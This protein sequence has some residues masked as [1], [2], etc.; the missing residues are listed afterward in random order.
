MLCLCCDVL[1]GSSPA[2]A[3]TKDC[4]EAMA[5]SL[6]LLLVALCCLSVAHCQLK[7]FNLRASDLPTDALGITD[8]YVHVFSNSNSMGK[9]STR[10]NDANPWWSEE[11][12]YFK[13]V[14]GDILTLEVHD[15]DLIFDDVV[16]ICDRSITQGTHSHQCY[17]EK[18]GVLYYEYTLG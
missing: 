3:F 13:A 15:S 18:G 6:P 10:D 2:T 1:S 5:C 16:G 14:E 12:T 7:V 11:F 9:T 17:L 4:G 8:G